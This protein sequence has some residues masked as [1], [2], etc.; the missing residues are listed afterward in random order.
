MGICSLLMYVTRSYSILYLL[1]TKSSGILATPTCI[2]DIDKIVLAE[3]VILT[4]RPVQV[5][6]GSLDPNL[7]ITYGRYI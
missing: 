1:N 7:E 5:G 3:G 2:S 4:L 6:G